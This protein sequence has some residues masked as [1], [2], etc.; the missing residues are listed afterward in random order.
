MDFRNTK[1]SLRRSIWSYGKVQKVVGTLVRNRRFQLLRHGLCDYVNIGCGPFPLEGF[2]NIDYFW[3]PRTYCFDITKGLPFATAS[4]KGIFSE[5]C[6]E[7]LKA[8]QC[9]AVLRDFRRIL[10]PGGVARIVLPDGGLYC[11]LY[12]QAISGESVTWPYPA[13][14]KPPIYYVN[15][16]MADYGHCFVYDFETFKDVMLSAGFREVHREAYL[17]GRDP[18]LLV[19]HDWRA[20]ESF[21][22]EG[23]V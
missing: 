3:G 5:H 9:L 19:E 1:I 11:R 10:K 2:C 13:P 6:L 8:E 18:K 16:I 7:H 14:G 15:R 4:V 23:I 22:T 21:Y 12:M 17:H 20:V